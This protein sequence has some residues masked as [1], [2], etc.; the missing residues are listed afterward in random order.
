MNDFV[1][2]Y[3]NQKVDEILGLNGDSLKKQE[4]LEKF[5]N[6]ILDI[7]VDNLTNQQL[8]ELN[9]M[10]PNSPEM[11]TKLEQFSATIPDLASKIQ[12]KLDEEI[13]SLHSNPETF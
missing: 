9:N 1:D 6:L 3:L 8:I 11:E 5:Q 4:L 7:V 10:D 13:Q 12:T 2:E